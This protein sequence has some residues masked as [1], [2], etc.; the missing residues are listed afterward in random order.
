VRPSWK[1]R[2]RGARAST[3]RCFVSGGEGTSR[4]PAKREV[5]GGKAF[6]RCLDESWALRQEKQGKEGGSLGEA[7]L[8]YGG[9]LATLRAAKA[10]C[11]CSRR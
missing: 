5:Y 11:T 6:V 8:A 3:G 9:A 10:F 1:G 7:G 4:P 2:V